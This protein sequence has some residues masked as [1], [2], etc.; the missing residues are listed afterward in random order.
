MRTILELINKIL[1]GQLGRIVD[2][3]DRGCRVWVPAEST[4]VSL[5]FCVVTPALQ[6]LLDQ[7]A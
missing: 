2:L 4:N 3:D 5:D 1:R 7:S 6:K